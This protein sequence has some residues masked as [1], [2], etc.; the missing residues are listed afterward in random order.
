MDPKTKEETKVVITGAAG[1][2][3]RTTAHLF[4][5]VPGVELILVDHPKTRA[6]LI[7]LSV[8]LDFKN[9]AVGHARLA[10]DVTDA[11]DVSETVDFIISTYSR[12]DVLVNLAGIPPQKF[13]A[14]V[15]TPMEQIQEVIKG[16]LPNALSLRNFR[17]SRQNH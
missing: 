14:F 9:Q 11:T 5:E 2:I 1:G 13:G 12:I 16:L 7:Q 10:S 3:G 17:I 15:H 4:A 6:A 8:D